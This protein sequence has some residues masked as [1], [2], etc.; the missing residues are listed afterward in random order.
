MFQDEAPLLRAHAHPARTQTRT[1]AAVNLVVVESDGSRPGRPDY[2]RGGGQARQHRAACNRG[3][4]LLRGCVELGDAGNQMAGQPRHYRRARASGQVRS[5]ERS[6]SS[7]PRI[8]RAVPL[9]TAQRADGRRVEITR[10]NPTR[11]SA[12]FFLVISARRRVAHGTHGPRVRGTAHGLVRG[13][14]VIRGS[15]EPDPLPSGSFRID[16]NRDPSGWIL[17]REGVEVFYSGL[18]QRRQAG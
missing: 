9:T 8:T 7:S 10:K 16:G 18:A 1:T 5:R 17:R 15:S 2:L 4:G 14:R 6:G 12:G 13:I 11:T 3:H